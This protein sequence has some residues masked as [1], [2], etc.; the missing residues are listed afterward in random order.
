V[1]SD[2]FA[3]VERSIVLSAV[4]LA[5]RGHQVV[6]IGGSAQ[7]MRREFASTAVSWLPA[8]S[9]GQVARQ[10]TTVRADIVHA[11]M[12]AAELAAV[13]TRPKLRAPI[14]ATRHFAINRGTSLGGRMVATLIRRSVRTEIAIS[15]FVAAAIDETSV[16]VPHGLAD[17]PAVT[18]DNKHVAIIQRL[19]IEKDTTTALHAWQLSGLAAE[20]W[21]LVIAGDGSQRAVLEHLAVTLGIADSVE[22]LGHVGDVDA[23]RRDAAVLLA[24]APGEHFGLSAL[25]AMACGLPVVAARGGAHLELLGADHI[26]LTFA[27]GDAPDAANI[28]GRLARDSASRHVVGTA[29]RARQ[30]TM[31]SIEAHAIALEQVYL[32]AVG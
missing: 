1:R 23:V 2:A 15:A 29:L 4:A 20:G 21:R 3:G 19:E 25:E 17:E 11:H 9:V 14:V 16:I 27:P 18:L 13:V 12:T 10:L 22:F 24:T 31:F 8:T 5:A 30:H 28:L 32:H 26:A 7:A 6:V